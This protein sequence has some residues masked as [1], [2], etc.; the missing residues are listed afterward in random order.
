M[1]DHLVAGVEEIT[2][3]IGHN[4]MRVSHLSSH[5]AVVITF[6][7]VKDD[8]YVYMAFKEPVTSFL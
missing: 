7:L 5:C 6:N 4:S 3:H 8:Q 2:G 1:I